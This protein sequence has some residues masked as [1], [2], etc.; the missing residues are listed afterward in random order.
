MAS[1][2]FDI[3]GIDFDS[4]STANRNALTVNAGAL[5]YN[6]DTQ[7]HDLY[8]GTIWVG[9]VNVATTAMPSLA[10]VGT[11]TTGVWNATIVTPTY[12]GTGINNA[13]N[14][15]KVNTNP[16]VF[17]FAGAFTLTIPATG[18]ATLGT[19][20][21][22]QVAF[23]NGTNTLSGTTNFTWSGTVLTI[24]GAVHIIN[25]TGGTISTNY[26]TLTGSVVNDANL[27]AMS[28]V[29]GT[30]AT[31]AALIG[32]NNSGLGFT[33]QSGSS[34]TFNQMQ[35]IFM[36]NDASVA[37]VNAYTQIKTN[38][39]VIAHFQS[40][41]R[42]GFGITNTAPTAVVD[43]LGS[44]TTMASLRVRTGTAPTTPNTGDI[45]SDGT[46][47]YSYGLG[48]SLGTAGNN[49]VVS[50]AGIITTGT[51]H[52]SVISPIYGGT[53][54]SVYTIGDILY[55]STTTVLST[56]AAVAT[57]MV[58]ASNG[59]GVASS[60]QTFASLRNTTTSY[61]SYYMVGNATATTIS[62][63]ST[64]VK[65]AGTTTTGS[66]QNFT[67]STTNKLVYTGTL[68][69]TFIVVVKAAISNGGNA[70]Q[71]VRIAIYKNGSIIASSEIEYILTSLNSQFATPTQCLVSLATNDYIEVYIENTTGANN[72]T[73]NDL[74]M[75]VSNV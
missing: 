69:T 50:T 60:W 18:T 22:T 21:S 34:A 57:G 27:P 42:V 43:L 47:L 3:I 53:G 46:Y 49:F 28:F 16:A 41:G 59:V 14:T 32:S 2:M 10:T 44:S 45:Y 13:S 6:S 19:G 20:V 39:N 52:G 33:L 62:T 71:T 37:G 64:Y 15:I 25:A 23:W 66:L 17:T 56:L 63:I 12:G 8:N 35:N 74:N 1:V 9:G 26:L 73:A 38:A 30:L 7:T 65:I 29:G 68:T 75:I 51:W 48:L 24:P 54:Q 58:L 61:G 72:L 31:S 5:I 70:N 11:I 40:N 4:F 36:F 55:A 67:N